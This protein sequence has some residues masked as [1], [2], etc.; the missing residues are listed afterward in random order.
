MCTCNLNKNK[1]YKIKSVKIVI[2]CKK[3]L[4]MDEIKYISIRK[5]KQK[6]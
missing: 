6:Y 3:N 5:L 1:K 4:N 2:M